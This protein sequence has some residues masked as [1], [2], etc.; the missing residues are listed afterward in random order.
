M[1]G[2][3]ASLSPP[4]FASIMW[5]PC[6]VFPS[7]PSH[8]LFTFNSS[9][10]SLSPLRG[11][12]CLLAFRTRLRQPAVNSTFEES[13]ASNIETSWYSQ[14]ARLE[15]KNRRKKFL[16]TSSCHAEQTSE[17]KTAGGSFE[18]QELG[19]E[20][21]TRKNCRILSYFKLSYRR[22]ASDVLVNSSCAWAPLLVCNLIENY[23][24]MSSTVPSMLNA[25]RL[26]LKVFNARKSDFCLFL[27]CALDSRNYFDAMKNAIVRLMLGLRR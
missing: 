2:V 9:L 15:F 12:F 23:F 22:V 1:R 20:G 19:G 24:H 27:N 26:R 10:T 8:D 7:S 17:S 21:N 11:N 18:S 4:S 14:H 13:I 6:V 3:S 5:D 16:K 25:L